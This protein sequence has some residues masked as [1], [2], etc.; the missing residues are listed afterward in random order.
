[1]KTFLLAIVALVLG[2]VA[3]LTFT[4][5]AGSDKA[6]S[7]PRPMVGRE[8][9]VPT[10]HSTLAQKPQSIV[11]APKQIA[12]PTAAPKAASAPKSLPMNP[13]DYLGED[14]LFSDRDCGVSFTVPAGWTIKSGVRW[15]DDFQNTTINMAPPPPSLAVPW[16]YYQ[17]YPD[18]P[19]A[20]P[21]E[22]RT[23]LLRQA[24]DK[25]DARIHA[26][27]EDYKNDP[28]SYVLSDISGRPSLSY[29]ATYT[30][31]GQVMAEYFMRVL[32]Q[33]GYVM[34][35]VQGPARDVQTLIPEVHHMGETV[36]L[37]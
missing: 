6:E 28:D 11:A 8:Q 5:R 21:D 27:M 24:R 2:W 26:G 3:F 15:G 22:A 36:K 16:M 1:M 23:F 7:L 35:F 13:A 31:N 18:L 29:F 25:E 34:Y 10:A 32:G 30:K 12:K 37:R 17:A 9:Q 14:N 19:P 20:T 33:S 4:P